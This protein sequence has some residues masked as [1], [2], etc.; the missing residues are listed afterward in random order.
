MAVTGVMVVRVVT[1]DIVK[2]LGR[3]VSSGGL[4][5]RDENG[6]GPIFLLDLASDTVTRLT[7]DDAS[8]TD[9]QISPDGRWVYALRTS[10]AAPSEV[11]RIDL[12][13]VRS[14]GAPVR[15][16]PPERAGF[17][18]ATLPPKLPSASAVASPRVNAVIFHPLDGAG[19]ETKRERGAKR[20]SLNRSSNRRIWRRC[21]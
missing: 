17:R 9:P 6:R 7:S 10:Y 12:D 8:F 20:A 1:A 4:S 14:T 18:R 2:L 11:V 13:A 3:A 16:S 5:S 21:S 19:T 15:C